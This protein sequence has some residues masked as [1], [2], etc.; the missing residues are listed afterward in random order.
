[1]LQDNNATIKVLLIDDD[2]DDYLI[3]KDLLRNPSGRPFELT[4]EPDIKK[5]VDKIKRKTADAYLIDYRLGAETGLEL[6]K[7]F[8]LRSRPEPFI[9]LTGS[10]DH[11]I[12]HR[13]MEQGI[14]DYLIKGTFDSELL[15]RV[16]HY[17][18]QRKK[19]EQERITE[20]VEVNKSKDEFIALA[21][22]QLRTPA[23]AV[24][25][26]ISMVLHG[27]SGDITDPQ[28]DFLEKAYLSNE[29]QMKIIN[30]ILEI[31]KLDLK[32]ISMSPSMADLNR[33][34][35][36]AVKDIA[37]K[38]K[39]TKHVISF[40]PS[41]TPVKTLVDISYIRTVIDNLLENA[42][43]YSHDGT[44]IV[45]SVSKDAKNAYIKVNDQGVGIAKSDLG[46]L[47][48]KF[49]RI[50]NPL[51]IE[52]GGTGLGLYWCKQIV[53]LHSGTIRVS[54]KLGEGS[55]F[56]VSIPLAASVSS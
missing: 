6:L 17:A 8:Q 39:E 24:K 54:S 52:A 12:E 50:A 28:K 33:I 13:A 38:A 48:K 15:A 49:S 20:L 53:A 19:I 55:T 47:F 10:G 29:R 37:S 32:T 2:E 56:T 9:L 3:I 27:F 22:H 23:T 7:R 18:I 45:V 25:Q 51:S 34:A 21:S 16:L 30:D 5:A 14:S 42:I 43:K 31:T 26:Y 44:P 46:Y 35:K 4:W 36:H 41:N 1:M 11:T 40:E